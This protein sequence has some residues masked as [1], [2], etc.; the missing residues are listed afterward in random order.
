MEDNNAEELADIMEVVFSLADSLGYSE[1]EFM[2]V[3]E[4]L[5]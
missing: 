2:K 5:S 4:M 1:E 3:R